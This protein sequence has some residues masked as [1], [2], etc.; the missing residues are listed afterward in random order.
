VDYPADGTEF[1]LDDETV[2]LLYRAVAG[3]PLTDAER[4]EAVTAVDYVSAATLLVVP[5][6]DEDE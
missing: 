4:R 1:E 2:D 6:E 5:E 3:K